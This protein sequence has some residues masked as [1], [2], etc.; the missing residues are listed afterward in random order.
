MDLTRLL[1]RLIANLSQVYPEIG[2]EVC[3]Q[4][5]KE[6]RF[7]ILKR[8]QQRLEQKLRVA[9][10]IG[11]LV[12]FSVMSKNEAFNQMKLLLRN[13]THHQIDM[14]CCLLETCGRFLYR[15]KESHRRMKLYLVSLFFQHFVATKL[16]HLHTVW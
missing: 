2:Q 4:L 13:F 9:R 14:M 8:D 15:S 3:D 10:Y 11:E 1:A 7:V 5:R 12:M 16:V 6:V